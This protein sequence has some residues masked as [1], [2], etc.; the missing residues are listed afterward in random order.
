MRA[1]DCREEDSTVSPERKEDT[2]LGQERDAQGQEGGVGWE[3]CLWGGRHVAGAHSVAAEARL[4]S[5]PV[6]FSRL[7]I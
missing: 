5:V 6:S 7:T 3:A 2:T 4:L 1:G